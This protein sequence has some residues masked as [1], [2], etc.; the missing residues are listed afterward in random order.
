MSIEFIAPDVDDLTPKIT[1]IGVGGAGG[2]AVN[3]MINAQLEGVEFVVANTDAQALQQYRRL[4]RVE[5]AIEARL[6]A[7]LAVHCAVVPQCDQLV[8]DILAVP[9]HHTGLTAGGKYLHRVHAEARDVAE[10]PGDTVTL[11][12]AEGLGGVFNDLQGV[13]L[14]QG[15]HGVHVGRLPEEMHGYNCLCLGRHPVGGS[16]E[17]E[18]EGIGMGIDK[19]RRGPDRGNRAGH[20]G[21]R[22]SIGQHP[23]PRLDAN[24][25]TGARD[26]LA[27]RGH[28]PTVVRAHHRGE[29]LL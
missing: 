5:T 18:V 12:G 25:R 7:H 6:Y 17:I 29:L 22:E 27:A 14:R 11:T 15:A 8:V 23:I 1:V 2:N 3:N 20:R 21:Q 13:F 16:F 10:R 9:R 26:G 4:K 19:D 24:S 28:G